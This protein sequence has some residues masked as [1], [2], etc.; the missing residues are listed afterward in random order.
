MYSQNQL[1]KLLKESLIYRMFSPSQKTFKAMHEYLTQDIFL[2]VYWNKLFLYI[3]PDCVGT[4][5]RDW[6]WSSGDQ[7]LRDTVWQLHDLR[8]LRL[9]LWTGWQPRRARGLQNRLLCLSVWVAG[10]SYERIVQLITNKIII[11]S[12]CSIFRTKRPFL[13]RNKRLIIII[14]TEPISSF[15]FTYFLLNYY[16]ITGLCLI[17]AA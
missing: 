2:Y 16:F 14:K 8:G 4:Y 3:F 6:M 17:P 10:S 9:Q 7:S 13:Y 11:H 5:T 12:I 1:M 15:Y